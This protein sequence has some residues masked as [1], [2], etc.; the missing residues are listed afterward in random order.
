MR[1]YLIVWLTSFLTIVHAKEALEIA[2]LQEQ[3]EQI[4]HQEK[5]K[6]R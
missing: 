1:D 2:R 3:T 4:K 5:I 6:V